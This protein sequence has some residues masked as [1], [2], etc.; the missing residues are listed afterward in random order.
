MTVVDSRAS[1]S[2]IHDASL[3]DLGSAHEDFER[4]RCHTR[5]I[6][7]VVLVDQDESYRKIPVTREL[8]I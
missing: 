4:R 3:A 7:V 5:R 2:E 8:R 6:N 1:I